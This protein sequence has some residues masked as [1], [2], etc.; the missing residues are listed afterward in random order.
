PAEPDRAAEHAAVRLEAV[1][2]HPV[3]QDD[4][5]RRAGADLLLEEGAPERRL[6]PVHAEEVRRRA[7][8]PRLVLGLALPD[9]GRPD[10]FRAHA[11]ED[12]AVL[13]DVRVLEGR[14][15]LVRAPVAELPP[16]VHEPI[17]LRVRQR[18][19]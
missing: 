7:D 19:E 8:A 1:A 16:E 17:R 15:G 13:A 5:V 11:L 3:A 4:D 6:D 2:P 18:P 14:D 12:A 9:L 10:P